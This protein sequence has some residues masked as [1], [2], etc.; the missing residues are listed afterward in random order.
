MSET[1][2]IDRAP[3]SAP[4][5]AQRRELAA[6]EP[7]PEGA[8]Q[9]PLSFCERHR[10]VMLAYRQ[11]E[12][13]VGVARPVPSYLRERLS[14]LHAKPVRVVAL[15]PE[16]LHEWLARRQLREVEAESGIAVAARGGD[17]GGR[18]T[19]STL[20]DADARVG[21]GA[22]EA[23]LRGLLEEATAMGASDIHI[24]PMRG[25]VGIRL[26]CDGIVQWRRSVSSLLAERLAARLKVLIHGSVGQRRKPQEGRFE[27]RLEAG[28]YEVRVSILPALR[29][30]SVT[31]RLLRTAQG[32]VSIS[33]LNFHSPIGGLLHAAAQRRD[34][35]FLATGPT[36]SGKTTT[37]HAMAATILRTER[38]V[39]TIEDP[40]EYELNGGVQLQTNRHLKLGFDYLL[41]KA[42]RHDPDALLIGEIRDTET[43]QLAIRAA[44]TGHVVL[45]SMHTGTVFTAVLRLL[46]LGC[47]A[48]D[49][50]AALCGV[51]SQRLVRR[52]PGGTGR[53][54]LAAFLVDASWK[55]RTQTPRSEPRSGLTRVRVVGRDWMHSPMVADARRIVGEEA[56]SWEEINRVAPDLHEEGP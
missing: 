2:R 40:V 24:T 19:R 54:P 32:A 18:T 22:G 43:A 4:E 6:F 39:V 45:A 11:Q 20:S 41:A 27:R 13:I 3:Q 48:G 28:T 53:V 17:G 23:L 10:A 31:L 1:A 52:V 38:R 29:G 26:R 49:V 25:D 9:Y 35:L 33:G 12:V 7:L 21:G 47:S 34:G 37:L 14:R 36:G 42:L 56:T 15:A 51:L 16:D 30:E 5:Q 50:A 46:D 55:I 44:L 8:A